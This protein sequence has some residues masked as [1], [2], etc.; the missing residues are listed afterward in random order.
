M[1]TMFLLNEESLPLVESGES[2]QGALHPFGDLAWVKK[3]ERPEAWIAVDEDYVRK[4]HDEAGLQIQGVRH[5][6]WSGREATWSATAHSA[7]RT[8]SSP[9]SL[10]S[11][12]P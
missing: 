7:A 8:S 4:A 1:N 3:P 9:R 10:P 2:R 12:R 11:A 6:A 5:G